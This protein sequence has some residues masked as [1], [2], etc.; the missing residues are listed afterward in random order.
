MCIISYYCFYFWIILYYAEQWV[1]KLVL[2]RTQ[3]FFY[4]E[5]LLSYSETLSTSESMLNCYG[6]T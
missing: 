6:T 2:I 4:I 3:R 5:C 1:E